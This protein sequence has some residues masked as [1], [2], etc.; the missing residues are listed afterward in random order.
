MNR[1]SF[2][3]TL[4]L[5]LVL[6][7]SLAGTSVGCSSGDDDEEAEGP[8]GAVCPTT[9]TLTYETFG[10]QFADTYCVKC[11]DSA[12]TGRDRND[13]PLDDNFD[14]LAGLRAVPDGELDVE[15]AAGPKRVNTAMPPEAPAPSEAERRQFGEWVACGLP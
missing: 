15:A 2:T 9:S 14:T 3:R 1:G 10:K 12:K 5:S 13:A 8:S 11:H 7:L 6:G 4:L